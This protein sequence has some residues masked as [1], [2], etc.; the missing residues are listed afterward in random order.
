MALHE[1]IK[2]IFSLVVLEKYCVF[3]IKKSCLTAINSRAWS[4]K[5]NVGLPPNVMTHN[6]MLRID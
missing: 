1:I 5:A 6:N 2:G 3:Q 4:V